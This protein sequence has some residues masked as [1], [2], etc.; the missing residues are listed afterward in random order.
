MRI[1]IVKAIVKG[2]AGDFIAKPKKTIIDAD[3]IEEYRASLK[4]DETDTVYLNFEEI[5]EETEV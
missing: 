1:R 4:R 5:E 2:E 3:K